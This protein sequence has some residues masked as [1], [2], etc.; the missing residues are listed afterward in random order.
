MEIA[1]IFEDVYKEKIKFKENAPEIIHNADDLKRFS[2]AQIRN[3]I[4]DDNIR[5]LRRM[6][7]MEQYKNKYLCDKATEHQYSN[8]ITSF[9]NIMASLMKQGAIKECDP[10]TLALV[11]A[12]PVSI[13]IQLYDREP[14]RKREILKKA[15]AHID[16][17]I[18]TYFIKKSDNE[19]IN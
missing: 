14:E 5:K 19:K 13:L 12:A 3:T 16:L 18:D 11:Y 15:E 7:T 6:T 10:E 4:N 17:F 1:S 2:M 9:T 8:I